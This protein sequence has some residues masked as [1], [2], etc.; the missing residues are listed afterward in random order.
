MHFQQG[1][2]TVDNTDEAIIGCWE[3]GA[4]VR[5]DKEGQVS[6][7]ATVEVFGQC[8]ELLTR[9]PATVAPSDVATS[10][11]IPDELGNE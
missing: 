1:T 8:R 10:E 7:V 5:K 11:P 2:F 3:R 9:K 4:F 6:I